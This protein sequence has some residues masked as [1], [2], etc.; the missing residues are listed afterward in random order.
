MYNPRNKGLVS[1]AKTLRKN[2]AK[3]ERHLWFDFL[4]YCTPRFRRQQILGN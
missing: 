1:R 3:E 2:M 4:R